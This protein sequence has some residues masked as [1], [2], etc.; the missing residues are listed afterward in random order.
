[1]NTPDL[2]KKDDYWNLRWLNPVKNTAIYKLIIFIMAIRKALALLL[3]VGTLLL[4][5]N[6]TIIS[7]TNYV[8]DDKTQSYGG[9][10]QAAP[11]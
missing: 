5:A 3:V 9:H 1:M 11:V 6:S 2:E 10:Y 8:R 4:A 7:P